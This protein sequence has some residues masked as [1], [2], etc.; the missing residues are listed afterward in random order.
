MKKYIILLL[1]PN[2]LFGQN[3][4]SLMDAIKLGMWENYDIQISAKNQNINKINN[5]WGNA[6]ALPTI[7]LSAKREKALSDQSNNPASYI[8]EK[9][10]S[11][12]INGNANLN[13]TLF[14]GFA[15]RA[16]IWI[17]RI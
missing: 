15:I 4:L 12:V 3:K 14:N 8:Q 2:L 17:K 11:T 16:N 13:W 6:G 7:N 10:Q 5:N 9:L 1:F